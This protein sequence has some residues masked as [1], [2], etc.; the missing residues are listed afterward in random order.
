ML[1]AFFQAC[2]DLYLY[3]L[4][5]RWGDTGALSAR[6]ALFLQLTSWFTWYCGVRTY[7]NSLEAVLMT[8]AL[9]YWPWPT[10]PPFSSKLAHVPAWLTSQQYSLVLGFI[11]VVIRPTAALNWLYIGIYTLWC[12]PV[13]R[14]IGLV[15]DTLVIGTSILGIACVIDR[16]YFGEWVF[17]PYNFA[18]FNLSSGGSEFYGAHPW[19]WNFTQGF[20]VVLIPALP[21]LLLSPFRTYI[22]PRSVG[23]PASGMLHFYLCV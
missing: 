9:T 16:V 7:S 6:Y 14:K 2:G 17:V 10:I 21:L 11:S 15:C 4:A 23:L 13:H 19:H 5:L 12:L 18:V 8:M 22:W 20:V 1:Q 3:K